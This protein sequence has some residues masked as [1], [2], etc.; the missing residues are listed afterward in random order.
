MARGRC[1]HDWALKK[2]QSD[3]HPL[4][5]KPDSTSVDIIAAYCT[6]CRSHLEVNLD[7]RGEGEGLIPC[8]S[9]SFALHHFIHKPEISQKRQMANGVSH[10]E[11]EKEWIDTQRFQCSSPNCSAKL[12]V[13]FKSPRLIDEWVKLLTDVNLVNNR[14]RKVAAEDPLRFEGHALPKPAEVLSNLCKYIDNAMLNGGT[15]II[16]GQNKKWRLCLGE[17]CIDLLSYLGFTRTRDVSSDI[18]QTLIY[19]C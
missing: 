9:K 15:N 6:R 16:L 14:A 8:P 4:D 5:K 1:H 7:F 11:K 2:E 12:C 10:S 19:R 3:Y 18:I 17:P 13:R